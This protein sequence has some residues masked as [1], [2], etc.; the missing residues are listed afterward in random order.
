MTLLM[1]YM[2][3]YNILKLKII[4]RG[5]SF[6]PSENQTILNRYIIKYKNAYSL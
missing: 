5:G 4:S 3:I 1:E 6:Y 2:P